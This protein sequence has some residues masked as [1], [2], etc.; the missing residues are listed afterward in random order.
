[1]KNPDADCAGKQQYLTRK[2]ALSITK[3]NRKPLQCYRCRVC[4][5]YHLGQTFLGKTVKKRNWILRA[6]Q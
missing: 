3:R 4:G 2:L 1:M 5:F 6:F